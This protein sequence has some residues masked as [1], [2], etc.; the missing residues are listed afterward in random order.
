MAGK[1]KNNTAKDESGETVGEMRSRDA[2]RK[3]GSEEGGEQ[4]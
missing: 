1:K 2:A 3:D 4:G